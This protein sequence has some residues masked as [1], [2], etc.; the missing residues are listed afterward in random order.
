EQYQRDLEADRYRR[1]DERD[2]RSPARVAEGE[3]GYEETAEWR[4][5]SDDGRR[6]YAEN[7]EDEPQDAD[8]RGYDDEYSEDRGPGR[9]SGFVLVAAVFALAVLGTAGAFAY[10]AMF[11]A[12]A[13]PA[14][15]PIIK[16]EGGPNKIIPSGAG[17]PD[18]STRDADASDPPSRE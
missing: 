2:E 6:Q 5:G 9:R 4:D 16:A 15:P 18:S 7:Y 13:L 10:R 1:A 11:G 14:L 8:D 17:T 3:A 12:P